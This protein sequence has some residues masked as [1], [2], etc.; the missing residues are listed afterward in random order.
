MTNYFSNGEDIEQLHLALKAYAQTERN[1]KEPNPDL[2]FNRATIF[3][4]LERYGEAVQDYNTAFV[5]DPSLHSDKLAGRIIDFVVKTSNVV[6]SRSGSAQKKH[7]ELVK[8][9]PTA[10]VGSLKFPAKQQQET[11]TNYSVATCAE[12]EGGVNKGALLICRVLMHLE[13]PQDV[14][15]SVLVVDSKNVCFVVSFYGTN[16]TLKDKV[17]VGD[18]CY[19]KNP[20][21]IFTSITFQ[22]R[23]YA[24]QCVK[25]SDIQDVLINDNQPLTDIFAEPKAVTNSFN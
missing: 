9:I 18:L 6:S 1:L 20:Q 16:K 12:L 13:R 25:V 19:I 22:G 4:Y 3:E 24:Y 21:L 14:P 2:F 23:M 15:N 11:P 8:S 10:L 17:H 7:Q 5:I